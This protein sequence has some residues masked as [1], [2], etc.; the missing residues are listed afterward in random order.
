M[1]AQAD[2]QGGIPV[3]GMDYV[4]RKV[5]EW[6]DRTF[7][8]S[9]VQTIAAH[10]LREAVALFMAAYAEVFTR[11]WGGAQDDLYMQIEAEVEK[12]YLRNFPD[13]GAGEPG[14][15]LSDPQRVPTEAADIQLMLYHLAHRGGFTLNGRTDRKFREIQGWTW[16]DPDR[17]GVTEHA[18]ARDGE[19]AATGTV[20]ANDHGLGTDT[21][22]PTDTGRG[23]PVD[24]V[25]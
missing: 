17:F 13:P 23:E 24:G 5:G 12:A 15:Y 19:G 20:G 6:G 25:G 11:E 16:G 8:A 14:A 18:E 7:P 22:D 2:D 21:D 10:L 4:Q 1:T 9:T 3:L